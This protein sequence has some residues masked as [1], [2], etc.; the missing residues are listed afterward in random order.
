F[1]VGEHGLPETAQLTVVRIGD[2]L[3][4]SVPAE[5]TTVLGRTMKVAMAQ[6]ASGWTPRHLAVIGLANGSIQYVTTEAEYQRQDYEGGSN[7]YGPKTGPFLV[8]RL[9]ELAARI[10]SD[11]TASPIVEIGPIIAYP[12]PPSTIMASP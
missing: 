8:R 12:G 6:S 5:I 11:R 2:A 3:F 4:A 1:V 9:A 10:P 7:L